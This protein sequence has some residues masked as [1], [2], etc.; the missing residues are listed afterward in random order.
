[1]QY[2]CE[3]IAPRQTNTLRNIAHCALHAAQ[4]PI[5]YQ[6]NTP[7]HMAPSPS[8]KAGTY[9]IFDKQKSCTH[10]PVDPEPKLDSGSKQR[11]SAM[12]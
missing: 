4:C 5:Q 12:V 10:S 2:P 6:S 1:M 8:H 7:A 3:T 11:L 9:G